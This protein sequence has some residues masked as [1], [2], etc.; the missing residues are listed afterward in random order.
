MKF[1]QFMSFICLVIALQLL[2]V[3]ALPIDAGLP[4]AGNFLPEKNGVVVEKTQY[5]DER[6]TRRSVPPI[7]TE[8]FTAGDFIYHTYERDE[9]TI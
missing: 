2:S 3:T 6:K 7:N 8:S 9:S 4:G 1:P 5:G